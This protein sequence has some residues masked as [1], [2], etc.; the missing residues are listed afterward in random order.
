MVNRRRTLAAAST[1]SSSATSRRLL[2]D[3]LRTEEASALLLLAAGMFALAWANSPFR[4][5]YEGLWDAV[6]RV[7]VGGWELAKDARHWVNDGLMALFFL[8]V[9]IEIKREVTTGELRDRRKLALPAFAALGG[10]V[11]PA[12]LY[13]LLNAETEAQGWGVTVATDIAFA[14]GVLTLAVPRAPSS[15]RAFLLTLAIVDDVGAIVVIALFYAEGIQVPPFAAAVGIVVIVVIATRLLRVSS[16]IPYV[17]LGVA[18]WI[19]LDRSGIHPAITGVV[20]AMLT[21]SAPVWRSPIT[22]DEV[23]WAAREAD[24]QPSHPEADAPYWLYAASLSRDAAS[25]IA[26]LEDALH[27]WTSRAVLPTFALAN[28]GVELDTGV[29]E[30]ATGPVGGGI[31]LGLVVGKP[32]GIAGAVWLVRR[33]RWG[34]LP[35]SVTT[36]LLLGASVLAGIG[37]TVAL[38]MTELGFEG[39]NDIEAARVAVLIASLLAGTL[40]ALILRSWNGRGGTG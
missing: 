34:R 6:L 4:H 32:V 2:Q 7:E 11:V 40:G 25:P 35:A 22:R 39:A 29:V 30:A 14:L 24:A 16:L 8:I 19:A 27:P 23:R 5:L 28:A 31:V 21:P 38:F 12:S 10:M 1:R 13:L 33:L 9:G 15:L 18:L 3:F 17:V 20:L 26:R 36:R 37:F